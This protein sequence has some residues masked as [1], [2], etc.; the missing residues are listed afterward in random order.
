MNVGDQVRV[1]ANLKRNL[2]RVGWL[3]PTAVL[4]SVTRGKTLR[5]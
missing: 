5:N 3:E 1:V 4:D 2:L